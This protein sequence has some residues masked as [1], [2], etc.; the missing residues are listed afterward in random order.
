MKEKQVTPYIQKYLSIVQEEFRSIPEIN[1]GRSNQISL[2]DSLMSGL[3]IFELKFPSLLDFE[4]AKIKD[5]T[6]IHNLKI[7]FKIEKPISDTQVRTR[8]DVVDPNYIRKPF[9]F[10]FAKLQRD[11]KLKQFQYIEILIY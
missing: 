6:L 1:N 11:N 8:L 2:T 4:N 7:L 9:K 10:I 3:A 5:P